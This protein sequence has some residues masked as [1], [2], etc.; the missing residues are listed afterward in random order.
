MMDHRGSAGV[1]TVV[2]MKRHDFRMLG[3]ID[4]HRCGVGC[5]GQRS[6]VLALQRLVQM[7][8]GVA[9]AGM[10]MDERRRLH[11]LWRWCVVP[12][13]CQN[14]AMATGRRLLVLL[15]MMAF[16]GQELFLFVLLVV[17]V[18]HFGHNDVVFVAPSG[19][20]IC[21]VIRYLLLAFICDVV[22]CG[23]CFLRSTV[24]ICE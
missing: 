19:S 16:V 15:M 17:I 12:W 21:K 2:V 11:G 24:C 3:R 8:R 6:V 9:D 4:G 22:C 23:F 13:R 20:D 5:V 1:Q 14:D 18:A 10:V 7:H